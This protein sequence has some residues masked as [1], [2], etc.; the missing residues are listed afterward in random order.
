[1]QKQKD[2]FL[3]NR[4]QIIEYHKKYEKENRV[5]TNFYEKNRRNSYLNFKMAH[6]IKVRTNKA[7][8]SQN[9]GKKNN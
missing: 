4:D 6:K 3:E 9:V 7:F 8:K 5:K 1:M 2:Y